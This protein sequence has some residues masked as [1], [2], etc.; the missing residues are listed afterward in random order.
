M[1]DTIT[2]KVSNESLFY[3]KGSKYSVPIKFINHT[4]SLREEDNKLYI[5]YN[6]DLIT[7]HNIS[8]QYINYKDE[9]YN[10]GIMTILKHK[11]QNEIEDISRKNLDLIN[12][13]SE[14]Q[15]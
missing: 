5:Y 6:K 4:L 9:H 1:Y 7:I 13:L 3:Y 10:E 14:V 12:R 2:V 8:N 15:K 11:T